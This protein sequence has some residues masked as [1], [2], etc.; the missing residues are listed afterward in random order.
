MMNMPIVAMEEK[1]TQ[2]GKRAVVLALTPT[3][4][5]YEAATQ[6]FEVNRCI[7]MAKQMHAGI[8]RYKLACTIFHRFNHVERVLDWCDPPV[9]GMEAMNEFVR[10]SHQRVKRMV[11]Y[12][13]EDKRAMMQANG[14]KGDIDV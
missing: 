12:V 9:E 11:E 7:A 5:S 2:L 4:N 13:K 14:H 3:E 6:R 10:K 8:R 1:Q